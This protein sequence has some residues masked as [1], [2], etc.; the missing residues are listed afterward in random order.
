MKFVSTRPSIL[1]VTQKRA[2]VPVYI[3]KVEKARCRR[4]VRE[5]VEG[6]EKGQLDGKLA[7]TRISKGRKMPHINVIYTLAKH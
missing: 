2:F 3:E 4:Q 6:G 1:C 5:A 7:G